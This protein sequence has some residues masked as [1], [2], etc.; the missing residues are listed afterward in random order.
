MISLKQLSLDITDC[1]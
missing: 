1:C